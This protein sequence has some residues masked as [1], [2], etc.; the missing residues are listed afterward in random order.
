LYALTDRFQACDEVLKSVEVYLTNFQADLGTVSAEI[1]TLQTR[2]TVMNTK[3]ENRK[4]VEKLLGPSVEDIS[5]SPGL[6]RKISEGAIDEGWVK[7]L[8]E[9]EKKTKAVEAK[10]KHEGKIKAIED[11]APILTNLTNRAV[12]RIRDHMVAQIKALRSP[13]I[14]AQIIQ[15]DRFLKYKDLYAFLARHQPQLS[16]EICQAY[17]NTMRWYYLMNF[18]R[19]R[20]SLQGLKLH[21]IY[22]T[23]VLGH[24]DDTRSGPLGKAK[25]PTAMHDPFSLG[26]RTDSLTSTS[27]MAL[28]SYIA[29][30]DKQTHHIEIP[31]R[32]FNRALIDNAAEEYMFLTSF[33]SPSQSYYAIS[34][35]F[36]SI[37]SPT[38]QLGNDFT[39]HLIEPTADALGVLL[40]VRLNQHCAFELQRRKVPTC[41]GY[42]N[43]TN[44]LL[45][46]RFQKL[47]D[48]HSTSL[49]TL[50]ASLPGRPAAGSILTSSPAAAQST[51]PH[52]LTQQFAN[53]IAGILTLSSEA[54]DDEPV[55]NSLGRLRQEFEA[56]L[57]KMSKGIADKG[58]RERFQA[59]NWSLVGT[60]LEG[61]EGRLAED[62]RAHFDGLREA[63]SG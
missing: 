53:F 30:E 37:F 11:L 47:M 2:S 1:E 39:K 52:P 42:I 9:L 15:Q 49:K 32:S 56:F 26:R 25:P 14:N 63:A 45:W 61:C 38:F 23:E 48:A 8:Q 28:P 54:G 59:N 18:T 12:E 58:K 40:C 19:Y 7:A 46:P 24:L 43:G 6:V 34:R 31:F 22:N 27:H 41:E 36:S 21:I 60:V 51:A 16:E 17:I 13:N 35:T 4:V 62:M 20:D 55:S 29:E 50:T 33:F 57:N 3:L 44:M 10:T 5:L